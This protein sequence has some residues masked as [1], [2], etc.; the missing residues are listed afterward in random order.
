M[1]KR[2]LAVFWIV[3]IIA[4]V[5]W[6]AWDKNKPAAG[7]SLRSSNPEIL[8]NWSALQTALDAEHDF[9]S[10]TQTGSHTPGSARAFIQDAEPTT[11]IDGDAFAATDLGSLWFDTNASPDNKFYVL[12]ATT[13]TWTPVSTEIIATMVATANTWGAHQ[14]FGAGFDLKGSAT[15]DILWNTDKF[16]VAGATGNTVIAGT[17]DV[18]GAA[19][20]TGG[21]T[22]G[23]ALAA[24][25]NPITGLEAADASGEAVH[26]GQWK[27]DNVA[28]AAMGGSTESVTLPNGLIIKFGSND[29]ISTGGTK[30]SFG[31]AFPTAILSCVATPFESGGLDDNAEGINIKLQEKDGITID[32]ADVNVD[33]VN[34]IA[35]GY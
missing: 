2:I 17:L 23:G 28:A 11:Q 3:L 6:G 24:G 8:A 4:A 18:T 22:L 1:I 35:I 31:T 33:K 25:S 27:V 29:T 32:S 21:G 15:S 26:F 14:T 5:V 19:T 7:T 30:I 10:S 16:T 20:L 9:G 34:W 12:T 13:P